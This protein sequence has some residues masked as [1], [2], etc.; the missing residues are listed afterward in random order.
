[1]G[2]LSR[3]FGPNSAQPPRGAERFQVLWLA[4]LQPGERGVDRPSRPSARAGPH[5]TKRPMPI[6]PG[7]NGFQPAHRVGHLLVES[8]AGFGAGSNLAR[9]QLLPAAARV[10]NRP[11]QIGAQALLAGFMS[12]QWKGALTGSS[13][14]RPRPRPWPDPWRGPRSRMA[15]NHRLVG[16]FRFAALT[17]SPW[18]ACSSTPSASLRQLQQRPMRPPRRHGFLHIP[19]AGGQPEGRRR[20]ADFRRHQR[21]IFARLWPAT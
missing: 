7:A 18:A 2:A 16:E 4:E 8:L 14:A 21:R 11:R 19:R 6:P 20:T 15:R 3:K 1:M 10:A 5:S 9:C 17:T 13:T 12:A